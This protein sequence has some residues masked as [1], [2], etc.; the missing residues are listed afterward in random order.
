V[1]AKIYPALAA[2]L[3]FYAQASKLL[4]LRQDLKGAAMFLFEC[5]PH[6]RTRKAKTASPACRKIPSGILPEGESLPT[7]WCYCSVYLFILPK[8]ANITVF[9][10]FLSGFCFTNLMLFGR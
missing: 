4:C 6:G 8:I 2:G 3:N 9:G 5:E 10:C 1:G 7:A